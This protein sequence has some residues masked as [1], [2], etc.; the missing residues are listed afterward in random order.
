MKLEIRGGVA[1]GDASS[2]RTFA[3]AHS[4]TAPTDASVAP[5]S[6]ALVLHLPLQTY[7]I[8]IQP[9]KPLTTPSPLPPPTAV[10]PFSTSP[11]PAA[12]PTL[13]LTLS[14]THYRP[15]SSRNLHWFRRRFCRCRNL[16]LDP[17]LHFHLSPLSSLTPNQR[18]HQPSGWG[19]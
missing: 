8:L 16:H 11:S 15:Q 9:L 1:G 12:I 2:N 4:A 19:E 7:S 13:W 5:S 14:L 17:P 3:I 10:R 6:F 18:L